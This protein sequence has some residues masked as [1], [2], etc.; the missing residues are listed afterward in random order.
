MK[1]KNIFSD[2]RTSDFKEITGRTTWKLKKLSG[3]LEREFK[4]GP[5]EDA[6]LLK[7]FTP[8]FQNRSALC[9]F[10][11]KRDKDFFFDWNSRLHYSQ[12]LNKRFFPSY[13]ELIEKADGISEARFSLLGR[14][15]NFGSADKIDWHVAGTGGSWPRIHWSKLDLASLETLGD[16]KITWE[17]NRHQHFLTLGRAWWFSGDIKYPNAFRE[18]ILSWIDQ[19]PA[20]TG[21]NWQSNLEIALRSIS[22]IWGLHFFLETLDEPDLF[23][24]ITSLLQHGIHLEKHL[25]YSE[26]CMRNNHLIG[27]AAGLAFISFFLPELALSQR[28][29]A[30][31]LGILF[32][33]TERQINEDGTSFEQSTSYLGF[34]YYLLLNSFLYAQISGKKVPVKIWQRMEK[35]PDFFS[36]I[37]CQDGSYPSIGDSDSSTVTP[38]AEPGNNINLKGLLSTG[39]ILFRR[40]DFKGSAGRLSEEAYWFLGES[41]FSIWDSLKEGPPLKGSRIFPKGGFLARKWEWGNKKISLLFRSGPFSKHHAHADQLSFTLDLGGVMLFVDPGTYCYNTEMGFRNYF[42]TT[43]AHNTVLIDGQS[44]MTPYR[45]FRWLD[46]G[47]NTLIQKAEVDGNPFFYSSY[48]KKYGNELVEHKRGL[49]FP[50]EHLLLVIDS[51]VAKHQHHYEVLFHLPETASVRRLEEHSCNYK[52]AFNNADAIVL[53]L[54]IE[55]GWSS[56]ITEGE[57]SNSTIQGWISP[58]YGILKP[59]PVIRYI[60]RSQGQTRSAVLISTKPQGND[61][62]L[63]MKHIKEQCFRILDS[64]TGGI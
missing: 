35:V 3:Y 18:Q 5:L 46:P 62:L 9:A 16:V 1:V 41:S 53:V 17:L 15:I 27:D 64:T 6:D 22:W 50:D 44:Q 45:S 56:Q 38:L 30:K 26:S 34:I 21:I 40:G 32:E 4:S 8:K 10:F 61:D 60:S 20:E 63:D 12:Q 54:N 28:W 11:K 23:K 33:E 13:K 49:A 42:R 29:Q 57:D 31:A 43:G 51:M 36:W 58:Y 24:I 39:S 19:N 14:Q 2:I 37:I 52:V 7:M 59:A 25:P 55:K 47:Q 48:L